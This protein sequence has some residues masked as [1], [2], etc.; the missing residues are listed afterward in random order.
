VVDRLPHGA[1]HCDQLGAIAT[2]A[3][4]QAGGLW[5]DDVSAVLD[6]NRRLLTR[7]LEERLPGVDYRE[8]QAG[9]LAWLDLRELGLG[10]DPSVFLLE[11]GRV[12]LSPGPEFGPQGTGFARLNFGTSPA[13]LT[14]AV[15]RIAR[16]A[17]R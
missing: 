9:Y 4:Y 12:A 1:T 8:P 13:L 14:E 16:A 5:L 10:D 17:L 7:L 11:H 15:D 3:A 6:H 2:V